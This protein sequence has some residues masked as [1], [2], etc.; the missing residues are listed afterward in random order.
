MWN[1]IKAFF[2]KKVVKIVEVIIMAVASAGLLIG[3][4]N[5][6]TAAKIPAF[7]SGI[8]MAIEALISFIQAITTKKE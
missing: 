2:E 3:G 7:V 1:K 8:L 6:E 5:V 4:V